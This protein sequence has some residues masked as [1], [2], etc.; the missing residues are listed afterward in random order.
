MAK[1]KKPIKAKVVKSKSKLPT[2]YI[3]VSRTTTGGSWYSSN[4]WAFA[5]DLGSGERDHDIYELP[6][7][8]DCK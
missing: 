5:A 1:R 2:R 7:P 4:A 6:P 8:E 3:Q